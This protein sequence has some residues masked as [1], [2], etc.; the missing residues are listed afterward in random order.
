[1]SFADRLAEP[2]WRTTA[3]LLLGMIALIVV[4]R[5]LEARR[6]RG[7]FPR[8]SIVRIG[9]GVTYYGLDSE[10]GTLQRTLGALALLKDGLYFRARVG[11]QELHIPGAAVL[12]IGLINT[13]KGR[14][15]RQ[16]VVGIRFRTSEGKGETAAFRFPRPVLWITALKD[17]L[18]PGRA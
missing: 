10:T 13:H 15:L 3:L 9:F 17:T 6:V 11:G 5:L 16:Y 14:T 4:L 2:A 8:E 18:T 12:N 7:K 1:M